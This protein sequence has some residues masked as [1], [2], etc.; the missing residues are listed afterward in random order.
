VRTGILV[1]IS[2][3]FWVTEPFAQ[4]PSE[5]FKV[6]FG[7]A[8]SPK[9]WLNENRHKDFR[10]EF[11]SLSSDFQEAYIFMVRLNE[12]MATLQEEAMKRARRSLFSKQEAKTDDLYAG[13][14]KLI[15]S[16][17]GTA[18]EKI[19]QGEMSKTFNLLRQAPNGEVFSDQDVPSKAKPV[20][21]KQLE[22][23]SRAVARRM[24]LLLIDDWPKKAAFIDYPWANVRIALPQIF[25]TYFKKDSFL[26]G[27]RTIVWGHG[28]PEIRV[29]TAKP[30]ENIDW[31]SVN[32]SYFE[33]LSLI[34]RKAIEILDRGLLKVRGVGDLDFTYES[35]KGCAS[36]IV[37][38]FS[39]KRKKYQAS[40][41]VLAP[42][43]KRVLVFTAGIYT[44][45]G[46]A[47]QRLNEFTEKIEILPP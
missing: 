25:E 10:T 28:E 40:R 42:E 23:R 16:V 31:A 18:W 9:G 1:L 13:F 34:R 15:D 36:Y 21:L 29:V 44:T 26:K 5:N 14:D 37:T 38:G 12:A 4:E 45:R 46:E 35:W 32:E 8:A 41:T 20:L 27:N 2:F 22:D 19:V 33:E 24:L 11:K 6:I 3:F 39:S 7:T 47:R 30:A 17:K 43:H